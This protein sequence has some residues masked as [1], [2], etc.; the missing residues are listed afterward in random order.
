[1]NSHHERTGI[2]LFVT[3]IV[4]LTSFQRGLRLFSTSSMSRRLLGSQ[5]APVAKKVPARIFFGENPEDHEQERGKNPMRPCRVR[6]DVYNWL[7]DDDRT[8]KDVLDH[9]EAENRYTEQQQAHLQGLRE[10][11]YEEM[12]SH[13]KQTDEDVPHRD[14]AYLYYSKTQAGLSY[15][16]H[17]RKPHDSNV[18][19]V[20]IDE[21][22]L[23]AGHE[24]S[25]LNMFAPSPAHNLV[26]YT[27]DHSGYETYC[28][29]VVQDIDSGA[30]SSDVLEEIDGTVVWGAD[31][32][33]IF[34]TTMDEEHRPY[35]L[36]MHV[37]GTPQSEDRCVFTED[38]NMYWMGISKTADDKF[39]VV[40]TESKETSEVHVISLRGVTG[41]DGHR[42]AADQLV[43]LRPRE[44]GVRYEVEHHEGSF[45]FVT[46]MD[47]AKS[48]KLATCP[49]SSY[50]NEDSMTPLAEH[51]VT[52]RDVKPYNP[53]QQID[54][55]VPFKSFLAVFGREGGTQRLWVIHC[56]AASPDLNQWK[57]VAFPEQLYSIW[58][59]DNY[60]YDSK[61]LRLGYSSL[62]TPKQVIDYDMH[63]GAAR[64]LKEVEVPHYDASQYECQRMFA[65]ARDGTKVPMSVVYHKKALGAEGQLR[66]RPVLLYGYGSYGH[67]IDPTFDFK[68]TA[69]LDRGVVYV[70]AHI[71]GKPAV[72]GL[73]IIFH[74]GS[75][76]VHTLQE[77][78][79]WAASGTRTTVST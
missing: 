49:V 28:M 45:Y 14:G 56:G 7:R 16:I 9:L 36:H 4:M 27:I 21:N 48:N 11:L 70:I 74:T 5:T 18:E 32:S 57:P 31:D 59:G 46:N 63:T 17:C 30:E 10:E 68:R 53:S 54:E 58:P 50:Y 76:L 38:D 73:L 19:T 1:M 12:L 67:S 33:T 35:K 52:W 20:V 6:E 71:R 29:H 64:I 37:L 39:L 13:L 34:Y 62:L 25:D 69:L 60:V 40:S 61:A 77:E 78:E 79:R 66:D 44:F 43:C 23:A 3:G 22:K 8:S 55:I 75:L 26:A 41:G 42:A 15:K 24:Y 51:T 65:T 72:A 47:K 2:A